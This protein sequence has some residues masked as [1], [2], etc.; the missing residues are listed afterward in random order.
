MRKIYQIGI[1]ILLV[2]ATGCNKSNKP[3]G[4]KGIICLP[5][6]LQNGVLAFYPFSNGSLNDYSGNN[7]NLTN[8]TTANSGADRAGNPNCAFSFVDANA[9]FLKY[10]NPA[11]LDD[12]QSGPLSISIWYNSATEGAR[13]MSRNNNSANCH[14]GTGEWSLGLWDNNWPVFTINSYRILGFT[15]IPNVVQINEWHHLVV[16]SNITDLKVFQDG[17]LMESFENI[18]CSSGAGTS[19]NIGDLYLGEHFTG[20]LDDIIIY[21]RILSQAEITQLYNLPACCE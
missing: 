5:D 18:N 12:I 15:P 8:P 17:V 13:L 21:N 19:Q 4:I 16:T 20:K 14:G 11:F 2:L 1:V 6:S 9:N 10:T 3:T 7:Y